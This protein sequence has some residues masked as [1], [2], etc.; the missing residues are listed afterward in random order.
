MPRETGNKLISTLIKQ[1]GKIT[2]FCEAENLSPNLAVHEIRKG[3]KRLRALLFLFNGCNEEITIE[4]RNEIKAAGKILSP[5]RESFVNIQ[6]FDKITAGSNLVSDRK[7]KQ[8]KELLTEK[9]R[10]LI[11]DEFVGDEVA[12]DVIEFI[13]YFQARLNTIKISCL[14]FFQLRDQFVLTFAQ[15]HEKYKAIEPDFSPVEMHEL[16]KV[17]KR[18]GYQFE[19]IRFK[20]PRYFRFKLNHIDKISEYMGIDHD[21]FVFLTELQ[22][23]D[24]GLSADELMIFENQIEH[25]REL[26]MLKLL[27]R[28]KQFFSESSEMFDQEL[29][30]IIKITE[31]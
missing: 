14:S 23:G 17:L 9:N 13:K 5:I 25:Q 12:S 22:N 4:F 2:Y 28:L 30:K 11:E 26:N 10:V 18:L 24:Y 31:P 29:Q 6:Y 3:Y 19:F 20:N 1:T 21:L 16:R 8:V 7:I 15:A 27:P